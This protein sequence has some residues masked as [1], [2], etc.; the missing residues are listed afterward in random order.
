[1]TKFSD[2]V[3]MCAFGQSCNHPFLADATLEAQIGPGLT[4]REILEAHIQMSGKMRLLHLILPILQSAGWRV[5]IFAQ[6]WL[7]LLDSSR[8]LKLLFFVPLLYFSPS[9]LPSSD[10]LNLLHFQETKQLN[11]L[12]KYMLQLFGADSFE[13]VDSDMAVN[14]KQLATQRFNSDSSK[15]FVFLLKSGIHISLRN[16]QLVIIYDSDWNPEN[17]TRALK[18]VHFEGIGG[19]KPLA[20]F[21]LYTELSVEENILALSHDKKIPVISSNSMVSA[22]VCHRVLMRGVKEI[23]DLYDHAERTTHLRA[24]SEGSMGGFKGNNLQDLSSRRELQRVWYNAERARRLVYGA[25]TPEA[26]DG[27]S[28]RDELLGSIFSSREDMAPVFTESHVVLDT[29]KSV[30]GFWTSLLKWRHEE[31]QAQEVRLL[32]FFLI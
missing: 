25:L 6:V 3:C 9:M 11:I 1:V 10:L 2:G 20:V 32:S 29:R 22:K 7:D 15:Q 23:F 8:N 27:W 5:V 14:H 13:R 31:W 12:D 28:V 17:D 16:V 4:P 19:K 30:E 18:K 21:R 24:Q 26:C